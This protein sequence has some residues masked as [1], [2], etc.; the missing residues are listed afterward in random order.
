V[1]LC[2]CVCVSASCSIAILTHTPWRSKALDT[3]WVEGVGVWVWVCVCGCV[4]VCVCGVWSVCGQSRGRENLFRGWDRNHQ[5]HWSV[6][7]RDLWWDLLQQGEISLR[8]S[9]QAPGQAIKK[10]MFYLAFSIQFRC[11]I[12]VLVSCLAIFT[13]GRARERSP[14][15]F[16]SIDQ[17]G[18]YK[19][20]AEQIWMVLGFRAPRI[21]SITD[22][23]PISL[24]FPKLG[25]VYLFLDTIFDVSS[26]VI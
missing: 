26:S 4:C 2:L 3:A 21:H 23:P 13:V 6:W 1:W 19:W 9:V 16:C 18:R 20:S 7:V 14:V 8:S 17:L 22:P 15:R 11:L 5:F 25:C 12:S 10:F 24:S